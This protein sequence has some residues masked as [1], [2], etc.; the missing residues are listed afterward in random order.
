M[1]DLDLVGG[2][3]HNYSYFVRGVLPLNSSTLE[4][5]AGVGLEGSV[6]NKTKIGR[7]HV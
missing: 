7:A 2:R 1:V 3:S 5:G 6:T 4:W